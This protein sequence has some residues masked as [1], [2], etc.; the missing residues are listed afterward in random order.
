[1]LLLKKKIAQLINPE[2]SMKRLFS[3]ISKFLLLVILLMVTVFF[4]IYAFAPVYEFVEPEPFSGEQI[5][6]PYQGMDNSLWKKGNFQIQ[7]RVWLGLTDGR[8]NEPKA[9]FAVY[10]QLGYDIITITDYMKINPYGVNEVGYVSAYEHGYGLRKT[11]QVC[12]GTNKVTWL[13]YPFYQNLSHKQHI[14]NTLRPHNEVVCIVHPK[15]RR[16][17]EP[18]DMRLLCNYDLLEAVS[19]YVVS[20][21]YWDAALTSGHPVYIISNDDSHDVLDPTKVGRYCTYINTGSLE[22]NEILAALKAGKAYGAFVNMLEGADFYQKAED[23]RKVPVLKSVEVVGSNLTVEVSEIASAIKFVGQNGMIRKVASNTTTASYE[24]LGN[25]PYIRTEIL[26]PNNTQF[27]L[28]PVIR[29]DG[30]GPEKPVPPKINWVKTWLLRGIALLI[31]L[32]IAWLILK[33]RKI[34]PSKAPKTFRQSF[35]H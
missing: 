16:G 2:Y 5:H 1:M 22:E 11:H 33:L 24:L 10:R 20:L 15:V 35:Y 8:K 21:N 12:L 9:I 14:L 4:L 26:F 18:E 23:H 29:H 27:Y 32:L 30:N 7:S 3:L 34:K 31:T 28:N 6:N 13:D 19:H 17:Y 25:D